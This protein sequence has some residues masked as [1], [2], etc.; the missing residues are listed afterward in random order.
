MRHES[1]ILKAMMVGVLGG[2]IASPLFAVE[3][4]TKDDIVN[5]VVTKDQLTKVADNAIFLLDTSSSANEK[6]PGTDKTI[7]QVMKEEL[8]TRNEYFPDLGHTFGIYKYTGWQELYAPA[9]YN[10][11]KVDSA[12]DMIPDKGSG[13]TPLD[14]GL[15]KIEP[16][17]KSLTG[18]TA[19]FV[20]WDGEYTG[21]NPADTAKRLAGQSDVC[22]YVI[23]SAKEKREAKLE[24]DV[25]SLNSCSRVIPLVAFF[26][27]PVYTSGVLYDV[28]R[29]EAVETT[30]EKKLA[31][32]KV[33][34]INFATNETKLSDKDKGE[35]DQVADFMSKNA[36]AYAVV[37][38]Y[39]DNVGSRDH[40]EGLSHKRADMVGD[41]LKSKGVTDARMVK[42][43][44]GPNNPKVPNDT[45][46]N[47]ATNRRVEV[48]VG[49]GST[50]S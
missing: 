17:L 20:F 4:I 22:F 6:F 5:K 8:K 33:D 2:L 27:K 30:T 45:P 26:E 19:V 15:A 39:T 25:A 31:G 41:Y 34:D 44:Y 47:Q 13:T 23:S 1:K 48:A 7:V 46:E 14:S 36:T 12:L 40:N 18:R 9:P 37:A 16:V 42:F 28:K 50:A 35:L 32:L 43:W 29:T 38:G 10:R 3:V 49:L 24:K 21:H 11:E